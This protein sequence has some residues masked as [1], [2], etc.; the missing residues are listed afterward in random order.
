MFDCLRN[1]LKCFSGSC[2]AATI[3]ITAAAATAGNCSA[4]AAT[5]AAAPFAGCA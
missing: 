5:A 2:N 1:I 3:A 4:I